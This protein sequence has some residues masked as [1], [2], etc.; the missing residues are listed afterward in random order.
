MDVMGRDDLRE[1]CRSRYFIVSL[2]RSLRNKHSRLAEACSEGRRRRRSR[3][4]R[5]TSC[6]EIYPPSP[7]VGSRR[8]VT[9][10]WPR[11]NKS[12]GRLYYTEGKWGGLHL[13]RDIYIDVYHVHSV[14]IDAMQFGRSVRRVSVLR[15]RRLMQNRNLKMSCSE[16]LAWWRSSDGGAMID[17]GSLDRCDL[18][19]SFPI[20]SHRG[21]AVMVRDP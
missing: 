4:R 2:S 10:R 7:P 17:G 8:E 14:L 21:G 15:V 20:K 6:V 19:P 3:Y 16:V 18:H 12:K 11:H 1:A 5:R 13:D 9:W